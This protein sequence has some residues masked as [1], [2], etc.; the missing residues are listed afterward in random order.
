MTSNRRNKVI[1][2]ILL[3]AVAGGVGWKAMSGGPDSAGSENAMRP[4]AM[5]GSSDMD[6]KEHLGEEPTPGTENKPVASPAATMKP[7]PVQATSSAPLPGLL[8]PAELVEQL[9]PRARAGEAAAACRL[10]AELVQCRSALRW[11]PMSE[12]QI[13]QALATLGQQ[14]GVTAET[15]ERRK[16]NYESRNLQRRECAAIP[17]PLLR[18]GPWFHL[19]AARQGHVGSMVAFAHGAGVSSADFVADPDLYQLYRQNAFPLWLQALQMGSVDAVHVWEQA[20]NARGSQF[21]A[22]VLPEQYQDLALATALKREISAAMFGSEMPTI[23]G[24][25]ERT[26]LEARAMFDQYFAASEQ[27]SWVT[28]RMAE[29]S[30]WLLA[31]FEQPTVPNAPGLP[32]AERYVE[33]LN[34][35][36]SH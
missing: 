13:A 31:E 6:A 19:Q 3:F 12:Q 22:G 29:N 25:T 27:F 30:A 9:E 20:L 15:I 10:A 32:R 8:P 28:Q 1:I 7:I 34:A 2:V 14:E 4:D 24:V 17:A 36:C 16:Y 33:W 21:L 35:H 26:R 11:T 18:Q 5:L 23:D